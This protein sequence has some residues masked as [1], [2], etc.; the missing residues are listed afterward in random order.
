LV[1]V[2]VL[3]VDDS[4]EFLE[5][6]E[7]YLSAD[8]LVQVVGRARSAAEAMVQ[9]PLL[10]PHL[11][12][13]DIHMPGLNGLQATCGIRVLPNAPCVVILTLYDNA[14]YRRAAEA[15]GADAFVSKSELSTELLP[16]IH[17]MFAAPR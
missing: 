5:S 15:A 8:P 2:R 7:R 17:R 3:L 11:V 6:A 13:M 16:L 14:E 10:K 12:L 1:Q 4:V 9:I